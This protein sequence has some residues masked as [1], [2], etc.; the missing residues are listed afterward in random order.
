MDRKSRELEGQGGNT[1]IMSSSD[2]WWAS[3]IISVV[4]EFPSSEV[5]IVIAVVELVIFVF[6]LVLG[7]FTLVSVALD[8]LEISF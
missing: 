2:F 5:S 1:Y 6:F 3:L 4:V 8:D 7:S